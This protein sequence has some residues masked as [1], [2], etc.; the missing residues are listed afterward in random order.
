MA[1]NNLK[2]VP[3]QMFDGRRIENHQIA[4]NNFEPN[5]T[6]EV[7]NLNPQVE[8]QTFEYFIDNILH[9]GLELVPTEED[10]QPNTEAQRLYDTLKQTLMRFNDGQRY[11]IMH[12]NLLNQLIANDIEI[13]KLGKEGGILH[14]YLQKDEGLNRQWVIFKGSIAKLQALVILK[15]AQA[16]QCQP[17]IEALIKAFSDKINTVNAILEENLQTGGAVVGSGDD[18]KY[19]NKYWKYRFKYE[20]LK[21]EKES[22][23]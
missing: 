13:R 1:D 9:N 6:Q 22:K 3:G 8:H 12:H 20:L 21:K 2:Y 5:D 17:V 4:N 14:Q 19:K 10:G 15:R 23:N 18:S 16:G 7:N 11:E